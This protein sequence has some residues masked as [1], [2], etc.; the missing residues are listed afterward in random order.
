MWYVLALAAFAAIAGFFQLRG[1]LRSVRMTFFVMVAFS[2]VRMLWKDSDHSPLFVLSLA[3]LIFAVSVLTV[4]VMRLRH[5]H[6]VPQGSEPG[7]A[8]RV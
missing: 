1:E 4:L 7:T 8:D 3:Q 2:S 6:D 5:A